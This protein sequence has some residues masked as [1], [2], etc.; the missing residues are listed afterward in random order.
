MNRLEYC[1]VLI[2]KNHHFY[3]HHTT[4]VV[5]PSSHNHSQKRHRLLA[6]CQFYRLVATCQQVA[7]SLLRSSLLQ[8]VICRL[9]TTCWNKLQ[10][11]YWNNQLATSLLTTCKQSQAMQT[12]PDIGWCN[13]LL[14]DVNRLVPLFITIIIH[15]YNY[16][17]NLLPSFFI[18]VTMIILHNHYSSQPSYYRSSLPSFFTALITSPQ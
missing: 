4:T 7:T 1:T 14:Q 9:V 10:Q 5:L 6:S 18:A 17:H 2:I 12:H 8:L 3:H 11:A 13:K 15:S 16:H